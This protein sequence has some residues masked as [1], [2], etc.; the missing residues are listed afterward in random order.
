MILKRDDNSP[1]FVKT[2]SLGKQSDKTK[3]RR[4]CIYYY[5]TSPFPWEQVELL[6][7]LTT[8]NYLDNS[9]SQKT[10]PRESQKEAHLFASL[11]N[12]SEGSNTIPRKIIPR[13]KKNENQ[14]AQETAR[15]TGCRSKTKTRL[16]TDNEQLQSKNLKIINDETL[17]QILCLPFF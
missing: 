7:I 5:K 8:E 14:L 9:P 3:R 2:I 11:D 12:I 10:R 15:E 16:E 13:A 17:G 1:Y 6:Y 4:G